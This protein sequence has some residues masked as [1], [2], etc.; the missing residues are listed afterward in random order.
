MLYVNRGIR[1]LDYSAVASCP[2]CYTI[3]RLRS[4]NPHIDTCQRRLDATLRSVVDNLVDA[5]DSHSMGVRNYNSFVSSD[6][7]FLPTSSPLPFQ[8]VKRYTEHCNSKNCHKLRRNDTRQRNRINI[9]K[10]GGGHI[11]SN[12]R[13]KSV[14]YM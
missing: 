8:T 9:C 6:L 2:P 12:L 4:G 7:D 10:E 13:W 1:K 3:V 11:F 5:L 14:Q